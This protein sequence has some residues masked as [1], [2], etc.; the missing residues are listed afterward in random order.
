MRNGHVGRNIR[1]LGKFEQLRHHRL[2]LTWLLQGLIAKAQSRQTVNGRRNG[3]NVTPFH[4]VSKVMGRIP[5]II[6]AVMDVRLQ[7]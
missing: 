5:Q 4:C 1:F 3:V 7:I 6:P 2:C